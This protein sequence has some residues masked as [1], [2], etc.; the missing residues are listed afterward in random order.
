MYLALA[1]PVERLGL[2]QRLAL[3]KM[4]MVAPFES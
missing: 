4:Q 2:N 1:A 3:N